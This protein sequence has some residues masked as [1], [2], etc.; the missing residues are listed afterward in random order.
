LQ[1]VRRSRARLADRRRA[2]AASTAARRRPTV[3]APPPPRRARPD[4][5][6]VIVAT[7]AGGETLTSQ[8]MPRIQAEMLLALGVRG[9]HGRVR[10]TGIVRATMRRSS[11]PPGQ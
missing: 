8:P 11:P 10:S 7:T 2:I 5:D 9:G 3:D 1:G 4:A 6:T